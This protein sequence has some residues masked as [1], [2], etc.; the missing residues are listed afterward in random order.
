MGPVMNNQDSLRASAQSIPA[1][2]IVR[3]LQW[4][5]GEAPYP[6]PISIH[7]N[8]TLRCAARCVHCSQ[9][10]WPEHAELSLDQIENLFSIFESWGVQTVTFGGGNPLLHPHICRALE[11]ARG[12]KLQVGII[13]EGVELSDELADALCRGARWVRFSLDGPTADIHDAIRRTPG[14]FDRVGLDILRLRA[15][16]SALQ[17]GLNHVVQKSNIHAVSGMI[18]L[19]ARLNVDTLLFKMPHGEDPAGRYLPAAEQWT[20]FVD[21]VHH[22]A[23]Q[24]TRPLHT[25]LKELGTLLGSM[26]RDEDVLRGRPVAGYYRQ[27]QARCFTPLFVLTCD[28]EGNMYP[29]DYLQADTRPWGGKFA[30]MRNEFC[31]GNLFEDSKAVLENLAKVLRGQVHGLPGAGYPE[32][33]DCTRFCQLNSSLTVLERQLQGLSLTEA[34]VSELFG[35]ERAD[36]SED[37]PFL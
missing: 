10:A 23:S 37:A 33:G 35:R 3:A 16:A 9:W 28:A 24:D 19:A 29:C 11:L 12:H 14:L 18:P 5:N 2:A 17:I 6:Y 34:A 8:L 26:F 20:Q 1:A 25:N 7:L 27:I 30:K 36:S 31:L 21:W 32:C 4:L 15:H 22:A 13:S